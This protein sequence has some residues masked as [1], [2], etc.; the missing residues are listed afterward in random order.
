MGQLGGKAGFSTQFTSV[1]IFLIS[2]QVAFQRKAGKSPRPNWQKFQ[3]NSEIFQRNSEKSHRSFSSPG[4][5]VR[6]DNL[7]EK[8]GD[9]GIIT[10]SIFRF[11]EG[12]TDS[13]DRDRLTPRLQG[14][15][16]LL[17]QR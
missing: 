15:S 14:L 9:T 3:S 1:R 7:L 5:L 11:S 10:Q 16:R 4:F 17:D 2:G 8:R 12:L 6:S 13:P